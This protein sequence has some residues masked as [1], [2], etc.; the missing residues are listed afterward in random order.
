VATAVEI[1]IAT[2]EIA[3]IVAATGIVV[4]AVTR[5]PPLRSSPP[6]V[7]PCRPLLAIFRVRSVPALHSC[8]L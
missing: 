3:V 6:T 8:R 4:R 7:L 2:V 1:V 5:R